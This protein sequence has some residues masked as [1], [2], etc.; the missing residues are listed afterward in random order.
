MVIRVRSPW[1]F[2]DVGNTVDASIGGL[3]RTFP[4]P[5]QPRFL[6]YATQQGYFLTFDKHWKPH[7]NA[8]F[9]TVIKS[10]LDHTLCLLLE[11]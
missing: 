7:F 5:G 11:L 9:V 4:S 8:P 3:L 2:T 10:V 6:E 1:K